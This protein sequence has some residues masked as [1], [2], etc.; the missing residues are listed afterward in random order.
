[1]LGR[2]INL[3]PRLRHELSKCDVGGAIDFA[4]NQKCRS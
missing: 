2:I 4:M 3:V 1:M